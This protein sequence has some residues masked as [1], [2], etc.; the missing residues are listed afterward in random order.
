ML[1]YALH[2][3]VLGLNEMS[4]NLTDNMLLIFCHNIIRFYMDLFSY[5]LTLPRKPLQVQHSHIENDK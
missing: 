1:N 3:Y 4:L 2:F 5:S